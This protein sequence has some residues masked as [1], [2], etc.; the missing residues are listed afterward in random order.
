MALS[1][2]EQ[3]VLS[4][5]EC[6]LFIED[7]QFSDSLSGKRILSQKRR[8]LRWGAI[9]FVA[10]SVG[11]VTFFT[12][13]IALSLLGLA[14]MFISSVLTLSSVSALRRMKSTRTSH[15]SVRIG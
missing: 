2:H 9:G 7:P 13:S 8:T 6:S 15:P 5:L 10:G 11:L 14:T 12:S 4:E 3:K 1:E